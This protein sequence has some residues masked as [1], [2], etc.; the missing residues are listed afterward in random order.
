MRVHRSNADVKGGGDLGTGAPLGDQL[1]DLSLARREL[2]QIASGDFAFRAANVVVHHNVLQRC[3]QIILSGTDRFN[4]REKI[5]DAATLEDV[6]RR[7]GPKR[8]E[9]MVS[10]IV[11]GEHDDAGAGMFGADLSCGINAVESGH[12]VDA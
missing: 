7:T 4:G 6:P 2:L 10:I 11:H 3:A 5:G 12:R 8:L 1:Q 9:H